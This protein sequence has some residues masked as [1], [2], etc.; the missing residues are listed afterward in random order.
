LD[1]IPRLDLMINNVVAHP[2][3]RGYCGT[4][5]TVC[6]LQKNAGASVPLTTVIHQADPIRG[7][8]QTRIDGN[9][10]AIDSRPAWVINPFGSFSSHTDFS[11]AMAARAGIAGFELSG[12]T[13]ASW[14]DASGQPTA[15]LAARHGAAAP[16]PSDPLINEHLP[17]GL[18]HYGAVR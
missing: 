1:W 13:G 3:S 12:M 7:I 5:T 17:V 10:Y 11:A 9:V 14:V 15:A 8:P 6:V 18:R 4:P 2:R 16:I